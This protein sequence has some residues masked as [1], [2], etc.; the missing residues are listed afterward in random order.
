M[1]RGGCGLV[2]MV[3][4]DISG[5]QTATRWDHS[6]ELE[7]QYEPMT[8]FTA[9]PSAFINSRPRL[10]RGFLGSFLCE[11]IWILFLSSTGEKLWWLQYRCTT[12]SLEKERQ[13]NIPTRS[14]L[15]LDWQEHGPLMCWRDQYLSEW[16][17][18]VCLLH[19]VNQTSAEMQTQHDL[20]HM[21]NQLLHPYILIQR[22]SGQIM[23]HTELAGSLL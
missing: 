10:E 21:K 6:E 15:L 11:D 17:F 8:I 18:C 13:F 19:G 1:L 22:R 23:K 7:P 14:C 16:M 5:S 12:S 20:H 4:R 9:I 3:S 2:C